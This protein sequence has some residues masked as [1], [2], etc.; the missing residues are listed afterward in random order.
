MQSN[1]AEDGVVLSWGTKYKGYKITKVRQIRRF[2]HRNVSVI[3]AMIASFSMVA[4]IGSMVVA[5]QTY[6]ATQSMREVD[7][8]YRELSITPWIQTEYSTANLSLDLVNVG[9]GPAI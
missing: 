5:Y 2:L 9:T 1:R 4:T 7:S 6:E 8:Y 3:T